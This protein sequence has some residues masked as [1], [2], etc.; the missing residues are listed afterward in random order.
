MTARKKNLILSILTVFFADVIYF[1]WMPYPKS[2]LKTAGASTFIYDILT[3]CIYFIA[4][5]I[6]LLISVKSIAK[7]E[8]KVS[9]KRILI[10][11]AICIGVQLG[12]D[13][14]KY[15]M[16]YFLKWYAPLSNDLFT[17]L[18]ILALVLV[19][20]QFTSTK[21]VD[22]KRFLLIT[23]PFLLAGLV[24]AFVVDVRDIQMLADASEK[25]VYDIFDV[26][27][28]HRLNAIVANAEFLYEIRNAVLDFLS[29][30]I[31]LFALYFS[32]TMVKV[33]DKE[34]FHTKEAHFVTRIAA[35]L[36]L[37][38]VI[39]GVKVLILPQNSLRLIHINR[40]R[41]DT[42]REAFTCDCTLIQ[43]SR[44]IS[45]GEE[46]IV[47]NKEK[48]ELC[49]RGERVLTFW[50][51]GEYSGQ[52]LDEIKIHGTEV[53]I[54]CDDEVIAYLR[55]GEPYAVTFE[56]IGNE[57]Y[58]EILLGTCEKLL[59]EG[60]LE[61]FEYISKYI[62]KYDPEFAKPYIERYCAGEFTDS[63]LQ[64]IG[65]IRPEYITKCAQQVTAG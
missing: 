21:T 47:Y 6:I 56:E 8:Y 2:F 14:L 39:C 35:I 31:V 59:E 16:A 4:F 40:F 37:S 17:M 15:I 22:Y 60:R 28:T 41:I 26:D 3:N 42:I 44:S 27:L 25:Y 29:T 10:F 20:L 24:I 49:Y 32:T 62:M 58:D 50:M 19:T 64:Q 18:G 1:I 55:E 7:P 51:D 52:M 63:E 9:K 46:K 5:A 11:I 34:E 45:Y 30:V 33:E 65:S 13:L 43:L 36:L 54:V 48:R 53:V 38:F 61:C 23:V 57:D 12:F